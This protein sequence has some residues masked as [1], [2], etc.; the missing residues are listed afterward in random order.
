MLKKIVKSLASFHVYYFRYYW[1]YLRHF[2]SPRST[3]CEEYIGE[4]IQLGDI[5]RI[6]DELM[7]NFNYRRVGLSRLFYSMDTPASQYVN[8]KH[9]PP[10]KG[11]CTDFHTAIYHI[12]EKGFKVY[13]LAVVTYPISR[14]HECL[15]IQDDQDYYLLDY[16]Y[17]SE[18][19]ETPKEVVKELEIE[20]YPEEDVEI[21]LSCLSYYDG[22]MWR[23]I[24]PPKLV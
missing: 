20:R 18:K 17:I 15:M 9:N 23:S 6:T 11:D 2:K 8:I 13:L 4:E 24:T 21:M 10:L 14:S 3:D 1:S 22:L 7:S 5:P 12:L 16:R 19:K